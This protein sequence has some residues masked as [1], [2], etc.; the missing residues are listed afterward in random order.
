MLIRLSKH[1][2]KPHVIKYIRDDGTE[3]WMQ[4]DDF[5]V[6]HDLSHF[7][8]ET[9]LGYKTA[10]NGMINSGMDIKDFENREKRRAMKVTDEAGYAENMA[11]LFLGEV[12]QGNFEDF[13]AVQQQT[14]A[15]TN[16]G[17]P[18][19]TWRMKKY[20]QS[21]NTSG[22]CWR[23]GNCFLPDKPWNSCSPYEISF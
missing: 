6:R 22:N 14:L 8:L 10:F 18:I 23:N 9:V 5:F 16:N 7:A 21:G 17:I 11:N 1:T 15:H 19:L 13:N 2:G 20:R 12:V 4:A 3:T